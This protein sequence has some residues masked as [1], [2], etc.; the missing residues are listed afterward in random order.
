[1][2]ADTNIASVLCNVPINLAHLFKRR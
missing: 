1:L 2:T